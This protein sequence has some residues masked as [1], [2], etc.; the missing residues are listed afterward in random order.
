[1]STLQAGLSAMSITS[2]YAGNSK[3]RGRSGADPNQ[4][5]QIRAATINFRLANSVRKS[6]LPG[7]APRSKQ[8]A[9]IASLAT[10]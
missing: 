10:E 9:F 5:T 6:K 1:M 8:V 2:R 7:K 3:T 4:S